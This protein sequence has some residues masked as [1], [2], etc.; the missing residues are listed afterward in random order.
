[1]KEKPTS[2]SGY[3]PEDVAR[4]RATLLILACE[5]GH[6]MDDVVVVGGI[7]PWLLVDQGRLSDADRHA[8]TLDLDLG[9]GRE[10]AE[11]RYERFEARLRDLGLRPIPVPGGKVSGAR[12]SAE[13]DGAEV[14]VDLLAS[15]SASAGDGAV[16]VLTSTL[17]AF[18]Y[19]SLDIAFADWKGISI[20]GML[21]SGATAERE[22]RV[23][24]P[25]AFVLLKALAFADKGSRWKD[26]YD[27]YYLLRELGPESVAPRLTQL[28][29]ELES[30]RHALR[31]LRHR[32]L[33]TSEGPVA[34]ARF[35]GDS[36]A[37]EIEEDCRNLV[38][39]L[40]A[41]ASRPSPP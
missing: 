25:A 28:V 9:L 36:S 27:I 3:Q 2:Q 34:A 35:Q 19:P 20:R 22:V 23:C 37:P 33:D 40:I 29:A 10:V 14:V 41:L 16:V 31:L 12:W 24:G 21:P 1:M 32:F 15:F 26:A 39:R 38:A 18:S 13:V 5:L 11:D 8:G 30:A 4:V 17:A 7:V 6:L